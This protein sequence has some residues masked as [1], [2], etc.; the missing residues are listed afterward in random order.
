VG[1]FIIAYVEGGFILLLFVSIGFWNAEKFIAL[2]DPPTVNKHVDYVY[3][4][5]MSADGVDG[6]IKSFIYA[7][8]VLKKYENQQ[9]VLDETARK[10]IAYTN[11]IL[12]KLALNYQELSIRQGTQDEFKKY[13]YSVYN[14]QKKQ[15]QKEVDELTIY[16]P[17]Q[18]DLGW[19]E[20]RVKESIRSIVLLDELEN[21]YRTNERRDSTDFAD[22]RISM[23]NQDLPT[24][25]QFSSPYLH[26][27]YES[28]LV[29]YDKNHPNWYQKTIVDEVNSYSKLDRLYLFNKA[30]KNAYK[31]LQ[32]EVSI[33]NLLKL[34]E[35]YYKLQEKIESQN[36]RNYS[37]D[38]SFDSPLL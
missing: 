11:Y 12:R 8:A 35:R 6:W 10:E 31:R 38:I 4:S 32:K 21:Y 23:W 36:E 7:D 27:L 19:K 37:V 33:E 22:I 26:S 13:F 5:R 30:E 18:D 28:P 29:Y 34:Q 9:G 15:L 24:F 20:N 16:K 25:D 2:Q 3:L 14:F 17:T 1:S